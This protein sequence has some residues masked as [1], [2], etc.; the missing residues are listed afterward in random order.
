M[1]VTGWE[2]FRDKFSGFEDCY[3][4][5]GGFAC[6]VLLRNEK[7]NFRATKDIDMIMIAEDN[8]SDFGRV[9]WDFIKELCAGTSVSSYMNGFP[10][11]SSIITS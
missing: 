1:A 5:I 6:E 10:L 8:F 7:R 4:V 3:A 2:I 11:P 9:F